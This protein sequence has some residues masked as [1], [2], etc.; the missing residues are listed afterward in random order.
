GYACYFF[1][2]RVDWDEMI[3]QNADDYETLEPILR[4][5]FRI[6][7]RE[8]MKEDGSRADRVR[9][10][11]RICGVL[12][13]NFDRYKESE[14]VK[15]IRNEQSDGENSDTPHAALSK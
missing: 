6:I 15:E 7:D 1:I 9:F 11:S 12:S 4:D 2:L 13:F 10:H 3:E 8:I 5:K 14:Y